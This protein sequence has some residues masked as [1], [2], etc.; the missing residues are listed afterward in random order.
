MYNQTAEAGRCF[1]HC[2]DSQPACAT[3]AEAGMTLNPEHLEKIRQSA[4]TVEQAAAL[5]WSSRPDGSLLIP[6]RNPDGSPQTMPDGSPWV[7]W[8]LPQAKI[9]ANP[10]GPKYLSQKGS[11]CRLYHPALSKDHDRRLSDRDTA[12]RIT[13][14]ELKAEACAAHDRKRVTIAIGGVD[15]WRDRR[16]GGD[17]SEPLPELAA[18]PMRGREVRLCFDSDV[19]KLRVLA[20]LEALAVWLATPERKG[21]KGATVYLERLPN[22]PERNSKGEIVRLGAD[23]M[24]HDHGARGFLRICDIAEECIAWVKDE[25][26]EF[27]PEF[28]LPYHPEPEKAEATFI[29][30]EY[31]TALLGRA[32]R[33]DPERPDG[34]QRWTGAHWEQIEGNDPINA[35]VERF[36]DCQGWRVARTKANVAG[37]IAAFRR[38]IEPAGSASAS[39]GLLPF[40]NGCL[41]VGEGHFIPHDPAHGNTWSL[42]F[43]YSPDARCPGIEAFLSDRLEDSAT[44]DL[45]RAFARVLLTGE[46]NKAFLE[47]TGD[48][49]TGKS[50][51]ANLLIAL[52]GQGNHAAMTLQRLEDRSQ[53][54]ETIK[55]RGRRLAIFSECQDYSGQLQTLKQMTGGDP[56]GAEVKGGRH[57]DFYFTGGVVLVG[58]GPIRVSDPSSAVINRRRPIYVEK[59]VSPGSQRTLIESDGMGGWRGELVPE[60]PGLVN[61]AL[62]M[63]AAEARRALARDV[64][65]LSRAHSQLRALIETDAL[66]EWADSHLIWDPSCTGEHAARVGGE[67]DSPSTFLYPSYRR[68]LA[69]QGRSV[70]VLSLKVFK[71]KLVSLLRG[72]GSLP[73]PPGDVSAGEYRVRGRGS[74]VPCIR[75]RTAADEA[76][77]EDGAPGVLRHAFLSRIQADPAGTDQEH[78]GTGRER[79]GNGKTP[80]GNGWN[81]WNG[82]EQT[83]AMEEK[84]DPTD[85]HVMRPIGDESAGSV[86]AVPSVPC[87]GSCRSASVPEPVPSVPQPPPIRSAGATPPPADLLPQLRALRQQHPEAIAAVLVNALHA[88]TGVRLDGRQLKPYLAW[89]DANPVDPAE[90]QQEPAGTDDGPDEFDLYGVA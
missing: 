21:G 59:V 7:R 23:D 14:G 66:A 35:A 34:W 8:R 29:R 6:Y 61:W 68:F 27:T 54:F 82:S 79:V 25:G 88:E 87:K 85:S 89:I 90:V 77:G 1:A 20:A 62:A 32:W 37:L 38:Q 28:R 67:G 41:V 84:T 51:L 60:L 42:P 31:L 76:E 18:I 45:F 78:P 80:I 81:G 64:Q 16:S 40:R 69:S 71:S 49:D 22:A 43:D 48:G 4:L 13:E 56:I 44:V 9:N 65:S 70:G 3:A 74:V 73:M 36:L 47:I 57:L 52:I 72:S 39:A 83:R 58:N 26:G 10:K 55:L 50:V 63:P 24:I 15:A 53:R 46:R 5:G 33:S 86:P 2:T 19:S 17:A 12:L 11:G 30:A 75:W